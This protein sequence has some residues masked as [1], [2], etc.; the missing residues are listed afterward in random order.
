[1]HDSED[2]Y[3]QNITKIEGHATL[4][5][6]LEN[7]KVEKCEFRITESQRFFEDMVLGKHFSQIPLIVSRICGLCSSSHLIT[8]LESIETAL[9]VIPSEQTLVLRE[10]STNGEF[11]KSHALHLY[12]LALPDY[13]GRESILEF[14]DKEHHFIHDGLDLKKAGTDLLAA[15]GG[16]PHQTVNLRVG[17]FSKFPSKEKLDSARKS[18]EQARPKAIE[19]IKLFAG[20]AK[21]NPFERKTNYVALVGN[22]YCLL[23]GAIKATDGT[24]VNE[25][26]Y[27]EH[28][29]EYVVPYSTAKQAK[30]NG[31]EYM[32]GALARLNLNSKEMYPSVRRLIKENRLKFPNESPFYNNVSQA[33]ELLQCIDHS[34]ELIDK[35]KLRKESLQKIEPKTSQ[36]IGVTEAP[37]G[38]LYH[39]YGLNKEGFIDKADIVVPT[40]QNCRNI[41]EDLKEFV[42]ALLSK[43]KAKAEYE[44]EK[45]IRSYDPCI[46]CS[47]HFLKVN[48]D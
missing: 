43:P 38:I 33:L 12:M 21:K 34:L 17:G 36:G 8:A 27:L 4:S 1:M 45:L 40:L 35:L 41:E 14:S 30:F 32:V 46:S 39:S 28:L 13:L 2:F 24:V 19:A 47:T 18:L 25:G 6:K 44:I 10:L 15:L 16:R 5:L 31:E 11:I 26:S 20:F 37:R 29:H 9:D 22:G 48:W 23:C 3:L 7:K 42:P